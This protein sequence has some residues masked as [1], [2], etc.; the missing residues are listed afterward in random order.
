MDV[1]LL[2]FLETRGQTCA[3]ERRLSAEITALRTEMR[4]AEAA[5]AREIR[6]ALA[7][8]RVEARTQTHELLKWGVL[9]WI[10][11]AGATAAVV[12]GLLLLVFD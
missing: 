12:A 4:E 7:A 3:S 1:E 2:Q 9:F 6:D 5:T 11:Q 10:G 8:L